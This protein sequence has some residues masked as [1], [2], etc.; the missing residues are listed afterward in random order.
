MK[1]WKMLMLLVFVG[2]G[3]VLTACSKSNSS[4]SKQISVVSREEGSG[5]RGAFIDLFGLEEKNSSGDTVDLTTANAIVTNSTSVTLTTVA[6]DDL[7]IGYASLGSLN[8]SVKVLKIDGTKASVETIK[9]G[10]YKISRPFNIVTK[11]DISKAA[12]DFI[13]FILSSDGQAIVEENGYIP[14][15]NVD[16]YQASVTSGKVV[17]SGSSS[18][19]PVMEK[20]KEAYTKVN[21]GVTIEIQQ[22]DS[23]TGITDT[24]DGTSDIGMASRELEDSE[25]AQ[26][27]NST[28][29]A[30]D[31]IA[32]IV[33]KNNT[34][35]N[36]TSEQVKS[37]FSGEITTWKEL[38]D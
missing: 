38:S 9:D 36:L 3:V 35:D 25:I 32:V 27:V 20:L 28:V 14:L 15:D 26:G 24:I 33:N 1:K 17:I 30:M 10:S 19:T 4:E 6:G 16:T 5:T 18:V 34:I 29:I 21:S 11:E 7:A 31:G 23:S 2:V 12:K 8:D 37:I 13:N 22:S